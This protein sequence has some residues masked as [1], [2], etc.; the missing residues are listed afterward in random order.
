MISE[1]SIPYYHYIDGAQNSKKQEEKSII[2]NCIV[3]LDM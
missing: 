1:Y 2:Y 3:N